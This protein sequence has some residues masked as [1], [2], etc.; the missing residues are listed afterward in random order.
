MS[1]SLWPH[2]VQHARF[3]CLSLPPRVCANSC[4]LSQWCHPTISSSVS[5]FSSCPQSFLASGSFQM[6]WLFSWGGQ[7]TGASGSASVLPMNIQ[8]WFPLGLTGLISLLSKG[9]SRVFTNTTIQNHQF[10]RLNLLYG[11]T[12]TFVHNYW[13]NHSFD[14]TDLCHEVIRL[15]ATILVFEWWVLSQLFHSPFTLI[16]TLSSSSSLS[17]VRVA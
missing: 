8:G 14:Y 3:P 16:K 7:S 12:V 5:P 6:S 2:G 4:P 15:D 11:L 17:S 1:D 9:L 13:I 10:F